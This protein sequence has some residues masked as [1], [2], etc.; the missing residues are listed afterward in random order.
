MPEHTEM[1]NARDR[2]QLLESIFYGTDIAIF[3][4]EVSPDKEFRYLGLNPAHERIS[5]LKSGE[6]RGKRPEDLFPD[7][8][9]KVIRQIRNHYEEC[10]EKGSSIEYEE[11]IPIRGK[12]LWWLSRLTPLK[13]AG[14]RVY[15]IIGTS[16]HISRLKQT[17]E[18][19]LMHK[20]QLEQRVAKRTAELKE[21]EQRCTRILDSMSDLV[22]ICESGG[23]VEYA[24]RAMKESLGKN[25]TGD[26]CY[27]ALFGFE[28]PCAW[29]RKDSRQMLNEEIRLPHNGRTY[30]WSSTPI[31]LTHNHTSRLNVFRDLSDILSAKKKAEESDRLKTRFLAT[32]S[33]ELRTPL[34]AIMGFSA[35]MKETRSQEEMLEYAGIIYQSG[36][37]LLE[38]IDNLFFL[39]SYESGRLEIN[40][41]SFS[42]AELLKE[43]ER[44]LKLVQEKVHDG[45]VRLLVDIPAEEED[46]ILFND[47]TKLRQVLLQLVKNGFMFT[48]E[49]HVKLA[50]ER[51]DPETLLFRVEDTG[52][53]ISPE[54]LEIIFEK[55]RQADESNT[56]IFDGTG[57]GL[58]IARSLIEMMGGKISV[59]SVPGKGSVFTVQLPVQHNREGKDKEG[60]K[61]ATVKENP[62]ILVVDDESDNAVLLEAILRWEGVSVE[63]AGNGKEAVQKVRNGR[64]FDMVLMDLKMPVMDGFEATRQIKKA[65]PGLPVVAQSAFVVPEEKKKAMDAGCDAFLTKPIHRES[66][67]KIVDTYCI[68]RS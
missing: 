67:K 15:R 1:I 25:I 38:L 26:N 27:S 24:N 61:T 66:L 68:K 14:G 33:H 50:L 4:V 19:L 22:M 30:Q 3:V 17:E 42:V 21:S 5:G 49:G 31:E 58:Y 9:R 37:K 7:V 63:M 54:K 2:D 55:F 40:P 47:R 62:T 39:T 41:V 13:N 34:N 20:E 43:I 18:E 53:G 46:T 35:L 59:E 8:P 32:M 57:I 6:I 10:L 65:F 29:C 36:E 64:R 52:I 51:E 11:M 60:E 44:E 48:R 23:R 12:N 45:R 28:K 16:T 56:R